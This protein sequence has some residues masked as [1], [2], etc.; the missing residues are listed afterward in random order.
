MD[1]AVLHV[2]R[3]VR[4]VGGALHARGAVACRCRCGGGGAAVGVAAGVAGCA[5]GGCFGERPMMCVSA[6]WIGAVERCGVPAARWG[7]AE[8]CNFGLFELRLGDGGFSEYARLQGSSGAG[9]G[10]AFAVADSAVGGCDARSAGGRCGRC[11]WFWPGC[12]LRQSSSVCLAGFFPSVLPALGKHN[13]GPWPASKMAHAADLWWRPVEEGGYGVFGDGFAEIVALDA[14]AAG[15]RGCGL[16]GR[17]FRRL[18]RW[19]GC[20]GSCRGRRWS[21]R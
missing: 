5:A 1:F 21:G 17:G 3:A 4:F 6:G 13:S 14:G 2:W 16:V 9:R 12:L 18:R 11:G 19:W 8:R 7:V 20:R 15:R 10:V